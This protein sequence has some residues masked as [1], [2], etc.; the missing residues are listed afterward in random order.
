MAAATRTPR[1]RDPNRLSR[2]E[3]AVKLRCDA[4]GVPYTRVSRAAVFRYSNWRCGICGLPVD[5]ALR[6][7]HSMSKSLDHVIPLSVPGSPGH[8]ISN[9]Q[10]AHLSCNT[11]KGGVNRM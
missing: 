5:K 2:R 11:R 9:C 4:W 7:P 6:F 8:V 10:L 3:Y 1:K